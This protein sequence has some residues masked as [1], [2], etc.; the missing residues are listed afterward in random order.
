MKK[1]HTFVKKSV[2]L[3]STQFYVK[4][5][6]IKMTW[7]DQRYTCYLWNFELTSEIW[8]ARH[9]NMVAYKIYRHKLRYETS[10]L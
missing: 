6:K 9:Q 4:I 2:H 10:E 1:I 8:F 3:I 7:Y 5:N